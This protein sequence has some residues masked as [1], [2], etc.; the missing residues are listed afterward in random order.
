VAF[1]QIL[2]CR[3]FKIDAALGSFS[4]LMMTMKKFICLESLFFTAGI[5]LLFAGCM[6][7][8]PVDVAPQVAP[9]EGAYGQPTQPPPPDQKDIKP[10]PPGPQTLWYFING[11]WDWRGQ[12]VWVPGHW[13]TRPHPGDI[14]LVGEWM[15]QTNQV[16]QTNTVYVWKSGHWRSEAPADKESTDK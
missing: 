5:L 7:K 14:W 10:I 3:F 13:R 2:R 1:L 9:T 8:P 4:K 16:N 6:A 15:Q 11:Y 12:Y